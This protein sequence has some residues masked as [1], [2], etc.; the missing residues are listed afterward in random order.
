[1]NVDGDEICILAR[2]VADDSVRVE[3]MRHVLHTPFV[4]IKRI[5]LEDRRLRVLEHRIEYTALEREVYVTSRVYVDK[6][7]SEEETKD[8]YDSLVNFLQYPGD[9]AY[10]FSRLTSEKTG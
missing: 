8:L 10:I 9:F 4:S 5:Q 2:E 7:L 6:T 1:M 3:Y